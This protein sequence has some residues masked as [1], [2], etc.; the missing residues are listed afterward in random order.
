MFNY[1]QEMGCFK[2]FCCGCIGTQISSPYNGKN[3][4]VVV[5]ALIFKSCE[6]NSEFLDAKFRV[7]D[8]ERPSMQEKTT[9][10]SREEFYD[11][12]N[13]MEQQLIEGEKFTEMKRLLA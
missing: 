12:K 2:K 6:R 1:D 4:V 5:D 13:Q 10:L 8:F 7:V 11:L 3:G 9:V